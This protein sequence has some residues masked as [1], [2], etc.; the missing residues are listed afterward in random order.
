MQKKKLQNKPKPPHEQLFELC[1]KQAGNS[2]WA[3]GAG[4]L[5]NGDFQWEVYLE[6]T[7]AVKKIPKKFEGNQVHAIVCPKPTPP[8]P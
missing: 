6:D 5:Q 2:V 3:I 4:T 7:K 1:V 8:K